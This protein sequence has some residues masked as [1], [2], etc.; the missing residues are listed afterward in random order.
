MN[1]YGNPGGKGG[2]TFDLEIQAGGGG[3]VKKYA[4]LSGSCG[5]FLE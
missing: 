1:F 4:H 3:G 5:F 2:G